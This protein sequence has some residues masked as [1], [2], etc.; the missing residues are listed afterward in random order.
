M[1]RK[2][3]L[4]KILI[5][6]FTFIISSTLFL[7]LYKPLNS[8]SLTKNQQIEILNQDNKTIIQ[9][10]NTHKT[11][12]IDIDKL[13]ILGCTGKQYPTNF[14]FTDGKHVYKYTAADS[15]LHMNFNN[16]ESKTK[17][18]KNTYRYPDD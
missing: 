7:L 8:F 14:Y 10:V 16:K 17:A 12:P 13:E 11:T 6:L 18:N 2:R 4:K 5:I 3:K 9:I 15:Q 1:N